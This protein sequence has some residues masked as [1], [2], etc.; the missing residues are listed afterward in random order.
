M[1][2][3]ITT[4]LSRTSKVTTSYHIIKS[5][6]RSPPHI[7]SDQLHHASSSL[8][9]KTRH[10]S[11]ITSLNS[12]KSSFLGGSSRT[13]Q[14]T[15]QTYRRMSHHSIVPSTMPMRLSSRDMHYIPDLQSSW[16]FPFRANQSR[17]HG[18]GQNL[19]V[20][21]RVPERACSRGETDIVAHA[22]IVRRDENGIHVHCSRKGFGRL[23][24]RRVG[25]VRGFGDLHAG[26]GRVGG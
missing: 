18:H 14:L 16:L 12:H 5:Q 19:S 21:V 1:Y 23:F 11:A 2:S 26:P 20:F 7:P 22:G 10:K 6:S 15:P 9:K 3:L 8:E 17:A 13:R 25:F 4:N 24:G